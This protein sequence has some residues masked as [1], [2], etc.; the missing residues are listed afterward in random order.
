MNATEQNRTLRVT[1]VRILRF[2]DGIELGRIRALAEVTLNEQLTLRQL[3]VVEGEGGLYVS[4]PNDPY[5]KGEDY[6]SIFFP[7]TRELREHIEETVLEKYRAER[8]KG[9]K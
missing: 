8:A 3:R 4:Y 9:G 2:K 1:D 7:V 6:R 5:Y